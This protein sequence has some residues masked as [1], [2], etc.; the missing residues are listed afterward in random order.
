MWCTRANEPNPLDNR[1]RACHERRHTRLF[2]HIQRHIHHRIQLAVGD[3]TM[4]GWKPTIS[5]I[6]P[7]THIQRFLVW[8]IYISTP[9]HASVILSYLPGNRATHYWL[10]CNPQ[11]SRSYCVKCHCFLF[12]QAL[13]ATMTSVWFQL[14]KPTANKDRLMSIRWAL[15]TFCNY[16]KIL[17]LVVHL[18]SKQVVHLFNNSLTSVFQQGSMYLWVHYQS[19]KMYLPLWTKIIK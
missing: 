11:H 14:Q 4:S 17:I 2:W 9:C 1:A 12:G 6:H 8:Y 18:T 19:P 3:M 10:R 13:V 7:P 5:L 15:K 16:F